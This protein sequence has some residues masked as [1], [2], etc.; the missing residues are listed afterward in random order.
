MTFLLFVDLFRRRQWWTRGW[1]YRARCSETKRARSIWLPSIYIAQPW[2][3][4]WVGF[5][6]VY[7]KHSK[8]NLGTLR[9]ASWSIVIPGIRGFAETVLRIQGF[10]SNRINK[11]LQN[12]LQWKQYL[13]KRKLYLEIFSLNKSK[14]CLK[15]NKETKQKGMLMRKLCLCWISAGRW[16]KVVGVWCN[17]PLKNRP[18]SNSPFDCCKIFQNSGMLCQIRHIKCT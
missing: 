4:L 3:L 12:V 13:R 18:K 15:N 14:L 5:P 6:A 17:M 11:L 16:E 7:L 9:K 1:Q 10:C 2:L 8:N